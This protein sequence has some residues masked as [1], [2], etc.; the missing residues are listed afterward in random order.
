MAHTSSHGAHD[1][2]SYGAHDHGH[3]PAH[4][5]NHEVTDIPLTGTTRV[6]ILS[7]V[8][9]AMIMAVIYGIWGVLASR[10]RQQDTRPPPMAD[11]AYGNRL[12]AVPRL[13]SVPG[14]DLAAYRRAHQ[15]KLASY[16]WVDKNAGIARIPIDRAIELMA[17]RASTIAAPPP[18]AP[19]GTPAPAAPE[20]KPADAKPAAAAA[21]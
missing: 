21:H 19:T 1:H 2:G 12:P 11:S 20:P 5:A 7:L 16:G 18:A 3:G 13:Q 17:E 10:V 6:A 15:E 9:I 8:I 14:T 4:Q